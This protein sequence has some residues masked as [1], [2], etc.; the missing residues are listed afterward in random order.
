MGA[1]ADESGGEVASP[2][3]GEPWA[4]FLERGGVPDATHVLREAI[5][6]LEQAPRALT[7]RV[8]FARLGRLVSQRAL[9]PSV[10]SA[11]VEGVENP[12]FFTADH[13]ARVALALAAA[14]VLPP[15]ELPAVI[16]IL[17]R[18]GGDREQQSVLRALPWLPEPKR[19]AELATEACRT[20]DVSVFAALC[21]DNPFPA[22]HLPD[23]AFFQM[24]MKAMFLGVSHARTLGLAG[25][26]TPELLR[27]LDDYENERRVAG[28]SVPD[29]VKRIRRVAQRAP[30]MTTTSEEPS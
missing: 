9:T 22:E 2:F 28:R 14:E 10:D 12:A 11:R 1:G 26:I 8:Q 19:F 17:Y 25:R 6:N 13:V 24:V 4:L 3:R 5:T 30:A 15:G 16:T 29:D 18:T 20:N 27:M 21:S 7:L 23:G